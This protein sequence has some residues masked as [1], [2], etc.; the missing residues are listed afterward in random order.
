MP[1]SQ[2]PHSLNLLCVCVC[3]L[4]AEECGY[5]VCDKEA[6]IF[7]SNWLIYM[8]RKEAIHVEKDWRIHGLTA[9]SM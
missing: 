1:P 4:S 2:A 6:L 5:I 3:I 8:Q 7:P 9:A